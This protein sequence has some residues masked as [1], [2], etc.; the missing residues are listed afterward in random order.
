MWTDFPEIPKKEMTLFVNK[1]QK[2]DAF[3]FQNTAVRR[4]P[5]SPAKPPDADKFLAV[6]FAAMI[7]HLI[8]GNSAASRLRE[9]IALQAGLAGQVVAL[10]DRLHHGP[11]HRAEGQSFGKLRA[12]YWR[13]IRPGQATE[14]TPGE[15][16]QEER[17]LEAVNILQKFPESQVWFWMAPNAADVV[18]YYNSLRYLGRHAGRFYI[19]NIAGLPFLDESGKVFFPNA[20]DL[21]PP[22]EFVKSHRL[23]RPVTPAETELDSEVW[24]HISGKDSFYRFLQGGK[25]ITI[26]AETYFDRDL[27]NQLHSGP[28]KA[29]RL[30]G[31]L[32]QKQ[33]LPTDE[34]ALLFRIQKLSAEGK[35][36]LKGD[37]QKSPREGEL[38]LP[39]ANPAFSENH[40]AG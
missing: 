15:S 23:A 1:Y 38:R 32:V 6:T 11:L 34:A 12:D 18:A 26:E 22:R 25:K 35:L 8:G 30:V 36:I 24:A 40:P 2:N 14:E 3:I 21:I 20:F 16:L 5:A 17:L 37:L 39:E 29:A 10:P 28:M 13:A 7:V 27:L 19:L 9:A 4:L 33:G 31:Q